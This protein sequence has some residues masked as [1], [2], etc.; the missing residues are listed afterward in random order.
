MCLNK[1]CYKNMCCNPADPENKDNLW[2]DTTN[3]RRNIL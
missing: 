1:M 3:F 2:P